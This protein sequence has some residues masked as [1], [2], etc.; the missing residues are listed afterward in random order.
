V[1]S[2]LAAPSSCRAL[3]RHAATLVMMSLKSS[4]TRRKRDA[5]AGSAPRPKMGSRYT[6]RRCARE[7]QRVQVKTAQRSVSMNFEVNDCGCACANNSLGFCAVC[8]RTSTKR[9]N[10]AMRGAYVRRDWHA[11]RT[12]VH[13][14]TGWAPSCTHLNLVECVQRLWQD[15]AGVMH[16]RAAH[17]AGAGSGSRR[18]DSEVNIMFPRCAASIR[19]KLP[20]Q[21]M[22]PN[23]T[24]LC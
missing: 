24:H 5:S 9:S 18:M 3:Q 12:H 21:A 7:R 20:T 19:L 8:A 14:Q 16:E 13:Y 6:H 4:S 22:P 23:W 10:A 11:H 1:P 15:R 17:H 2:P